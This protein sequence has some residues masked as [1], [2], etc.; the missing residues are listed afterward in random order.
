MATVDGLTGLYNRNHFFAEADRQLRLARRH[1]WP[2]A[3]VMVDIDHFKRI[4]DTYGHPVGDEV[5]RVVA[6]RLRDAVRDGDVLGRYGGEEFALVTPQPGTSAAD[7]AERLR[8]VVS[9]DPVP[10]GA[11]R[12]P[13]T[14]SV[15]LA[16]AG[17]GGPDLRQ[18]LSRADEALYQAKLTGRN[19]VCIAP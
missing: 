14:I 2:I 9:D 19:R 5:I 18:L 11:G 10:T 13:I 12:L 4:N 15:G 6:A 17:G 8:R 1:G 3:A 7:L 16:P